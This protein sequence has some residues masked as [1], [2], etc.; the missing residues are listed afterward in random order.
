MVEKLFI[1]SQNDGITLTTVSLDKEDDK[2]KKVSKRKISHAFDARRQ[3]TTPMSVK[4]G[5]NMLIMVNHS[6]D[7][8][9]KETHDK[10]SDKLK[11]DNDDD[12]N[13][14]DNDKDNSRVSEE[15]ANNHLEN[16]SEQSVNQDQDD[17]SA[18]ADDDLARTEYN[19]TQVAI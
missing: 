17:R 6:S 16:D 5:T 3:C 7:P 9:R 2:N 1:L 18:S 19:Q 4:K 15:E 12:T 10:T 14:V 8:E 13:E 11:Q